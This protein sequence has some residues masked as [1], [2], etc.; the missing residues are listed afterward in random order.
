MN[1]LLKKIDVE[2]G[3]IRARL[4][5]IYEFLQSAKL[6][7]IS[8]QA[9]GTVRDN[10]IRYQNSQADSLEQK[11]KNLRHERILMITEKTKD[12]VLAELDTVHWQMMNEDITVA[13]AET[14]T[15]ALEKMLSEA[16]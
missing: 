1:D 10:N 16:K 4:E 2:I 14:K 12:A 13:D 7:E 9:Y 11:L 8:G 3:S 15:L 6:G 5:V